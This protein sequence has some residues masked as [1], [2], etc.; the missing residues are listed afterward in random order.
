MDEIPAS[1]NPKIGVYGN[2]PNYKQAFWRKNYPKLSE[3][4]T[5]YDPTNLLWVTPGVNGEMMTVKSG[6]V[7]KNNQPSK[8]AMSV[9][10]YSD[11]APYM[12]ISQLLALTQ[13]TEILSRRPAADKWIGLQ[14]M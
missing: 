12:S 14:P 9:A 10:E 7:C 5:K 6:R 3:I 13:N 4:K 8:D 11:N 1:L 2:E